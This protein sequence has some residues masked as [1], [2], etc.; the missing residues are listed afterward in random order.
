MKCVFTSVK[1]VF[2]SMSS[3]VKMAYLIHQIFHDRGEYTEHLHLGWVGCVFTSGPMA[4]L[5]RH[6][7]PTL[8]VST[9]IFTSKSWNI[10][11]L[12][13]EDSWGTTWVLNVQRQIQ[14]TYFESDFLGNTFQT[15]REQENEQLV[16]WNIWNS[17]APESRAIH[18]VTNT[19]K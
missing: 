2:T 15:A 11:S 6:I 8:D 18:K 4:L 3:D 14:T 9:H 1:C 19:P 16:H 10:C 7:P 12:Y 5:W 17:S 13:T